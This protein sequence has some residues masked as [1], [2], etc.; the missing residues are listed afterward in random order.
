MKIQCMAKRQ[1]KRQ[2]ENETARKQGS[3]SIGRTRGLT[4]MVTSLFA[5]PMTGAEIMATTL[6]I[7]RWPIREQ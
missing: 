6:V 2:L 7:S 3:S 4:V 1:K 5:W